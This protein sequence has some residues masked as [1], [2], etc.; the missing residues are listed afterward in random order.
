MLASIVDVQIDRT[1]IKRV[2]ILQLWASNMYARINNILR[3]YSIDDQFKY[4]PRAF[5]FVQEMIRFFY[6]NGVKSDKFE[7]HM[8][9]FRGINGNFRIEQSYLDKGFIAT[10][11]SKEIG[12][13]FATNSVGCGTLEVFKIAQ[14]PK[15]VPFVIINEKIN[16]LY[17]EKEI[18]ML[19]G[20][21]HLANEIGT[22]T[23]K[24]VQKTRKL[25]NEVDVKYE[26]DRSLVK[27]YLDKPAPNFKEYKGGNCN[28]TNSTM[29]I[30]EKLDI[31]PGKNVVFY[32]AVTGHNAEVLNVL[33]IP[34]E[35]DA[36]SR[37]M[38]YEL[39]LAIDFYETV[40]ELIPEVRQLRNSKMT[41]RIFAKLMSYNV[42][43]A[44]FDVQSKTIVC[45][46]GLTPCDL[47]LEL[48]AQERTNDVINA[49]QKYYEQR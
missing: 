6:H 32:R 1:T 31:F 11:I 48:F 39:R 3:N 38:R 16:P 23:A 43:F 41:K 12:C 9:I 27:Q 8:C 2:G 47:H 5:Y 49:I 14:M 33:H 7:Q 44:V 15:D 10:S 37:F 20:W 40:T 24:K 36:F 13:S 42:H 26:I 4:A 22:G 19:P 29:D 45:L 28:R 25:Y 34:V 21:I 46:D 30:Q 18:L 35:K 17:R